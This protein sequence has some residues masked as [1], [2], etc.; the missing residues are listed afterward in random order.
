MTHVENKN[1]LHD[2]N[3]KTNDYDHNSIKDDP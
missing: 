3:N 2:S 1:I